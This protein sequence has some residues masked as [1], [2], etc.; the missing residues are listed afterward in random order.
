LKADG[1][2]TGGARACSETADPTAFRHFVF[3][4]E[5]LDRQ[6]RESAIA[7]FLAGIGEKRTISGTAQG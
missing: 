6:R 3:A 7:A 4:D 1:P 2:A 5:F